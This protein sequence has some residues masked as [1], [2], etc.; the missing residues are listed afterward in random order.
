MNYSLNTT[1]VKNSSFICKMKALFS[2]GRAALKGRDGRLPSS[3][4]PSSPLLHALSKAEPSLIPCWFSVRLSL[5]RMLDSATNS[6]ELASSIRKAFDGRL[7]RELGRKVAF[8]FL[9]EADPHPKALVE[10]KD[11]IYGFLFLREG[12]LGAARDALMLRNP[13]YCEDESMAELKMAFLRDPGELASIETMMLRHLGEGAKLSM[14]RSVMEPFLELWGAAKNS[15][16][17]ASAIH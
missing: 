7:K 8:V 12:E 15:V 9:L 2:L 17:S 3:F 10:W 5:F 6:R 13:D 14:S 1:S 4:L 11:T 16:N